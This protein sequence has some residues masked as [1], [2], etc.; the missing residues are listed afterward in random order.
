[1]HTSSCRY[2]RCTAGRSFRDS[3]EAHFSSL[4]LVAKQRTAWREQAASPLLL[5]SVITRAF[6]AQYL[7]LCS[8]NCA[9]A[10]SKHLVLLGA[11]IQGR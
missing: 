11:A 10:F 1:M 5:L 3:S 2:R 9:S 4:L 6:S 8:Q 7:S